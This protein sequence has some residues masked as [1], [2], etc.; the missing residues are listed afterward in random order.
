MTEKMFRGNTQT[1]IYSSFNYFFRKLMED[2]M[3]SKD[4]VLNMRLMF[5]R[6]EEN[7]LKLELE[8]IALK[9]V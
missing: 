3:L 4:G 5:K 8:R 9:Y 2:L 7:Y 1:V 6:R